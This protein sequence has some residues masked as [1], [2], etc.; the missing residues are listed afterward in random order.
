MKMVFFIPPSQRRLAMLAAQAD[1][2]PVLICGASGT[3]KGAIARWIHTNGPRSAKPF[4]E[5]NRNVPL[6]DQIPMAQGGTLLVHEV[7]EWPLGE[8]KNLLHYLKTKTIPV[9]DPPNAGKIS[10]NKMIL[11]TRI[12][13]TT[14]HSLEGRAQA[15]LF[16]AEL[17]ETLNVFRIEM[18]A[19]SRRLDEF[20]D[21]VIEILGEIARDLHKEYI[22]TLSQ[23]ALAQLKKYDWP[24]NI[25]E[26]RNVLRAAAL[27]AKEDQIEL[28]NLPQ[29]GH[30][31]VDF[32][33]T[34]EQFEK[35]YILGLLRTFH[36]EI[37]KTCEMAHVDRK[38]LIE[39]MSRYGIRPPQK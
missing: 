34:R 29:F 14:S 26:L 21:I 15:G 35:N 32:R 22:K 16:N 10:A 13:A 27:S 33:A 1:T 17:L 9:I 24:G 4:F 28:T 39:K 37:D 5:T 7:S 11:N 25:R 2:A 12:I 19:L 38:V 23:E 30:E 36:W 6:L 20:E 3:G 18:P 31:E 8:Q